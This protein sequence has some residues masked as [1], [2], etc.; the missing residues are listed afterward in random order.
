[1]FPHTA[2]ERDVA[3]AEYPESPGMRP[4][5][6]FFR[7]VEIELHVLP[8]FIVFHVHDS[9]KREVSQ[10]VSRDSP[11]IFQMLGVD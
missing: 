11:S 4:R 6:T 1:M 7:L 8:L 9:D 5:G 3:V 10:V 2:A